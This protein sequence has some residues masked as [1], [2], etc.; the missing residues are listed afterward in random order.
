MALLQIGLQT[1][2]G[3]ALA[4]GGRRTELG[5][6]AMTQIVGLRKH[7]RTV[8]KTELQRLLKINPN[9]FYDL[10]PYALALGLDCTFS[11]RFGR[12]RMTECTY[13]IKGTSGQ[14]TAAEWAAML[15]DTVNRLNARSKRVLWEKL[16]G[17]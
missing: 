17:R 12:L 5:R 15:R 8:S 2:A 10:A 11:R 13:L 14:M 1:L 3:L 9:Y 4:Y 7:M 16:T 6:Q